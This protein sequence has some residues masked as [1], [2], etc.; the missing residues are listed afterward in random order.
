M[1]EEQAYFSW[2][3]EDEFQDNLNEHKDRIDGYGAAKGSS[4]Y[5]TFIDIEPNSSVRP[6]FTHTDYYYFRPDERPPSH[7]KGAIR[8]SM[9]AYQSV[10]IV[11]NVIDLMGDFGSSGMTVTHPNPA[12]EKFY[13]SWWRAV[14]GSER[15]E[16]ILNTLFRCGTVIVRR[17]EGKL[18]KKIRREMSTATFGNEKVKRMNVPATYDI[19]NPLMVE[20]DGTVLDLFEG[21][22]KYKLLISKN[23]KQKLGN[24]DLTDRFSYNGTDGIP[25]NDDEIRVYHYKKDDWQVWADPMITPILDDIKMM[26]KMKLADMAALDGAISN[27]RLWRVGD[28]EHKILPTKATIDRLS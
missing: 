19:L 14:R 18:N 13:R 17:R 24:L 21:N 23:M 25:L 15:S 9:N 11:R 1:A 28:L 2:G 8:M 7:Q 16:R 12:I 22:I 4:S 10:G 27:V 5:R 26:E 6:Q 3:N 20:V